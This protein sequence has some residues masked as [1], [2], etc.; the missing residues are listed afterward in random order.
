MSGMNTALIVIDVQEEY[1]SGGLPIQFPPREGSLELIGKAMD[2]ASAAEIPVVLVRHIGA[3]GEGVFQ[4]D[5]PTWAL[6]PEV[7]DRP[8][9]LLIDKRLPGSFTGTGLHDWLAERDIDHITIVGYMTNVCCD[10]TARQAM[11]MGMGATILHD[12][13]G[14][15]TMPDIDGQPIDAQALQRSA[16]AP[17]AL[18]GVDIQPTQTWIEGLAG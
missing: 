5:T 8:H 6:R 7:A 16:L 18:I 3:D 2:S 9:D 15:P 10:T 17:L 13:V 12:A 4:Q 1:F 14:V 11:H